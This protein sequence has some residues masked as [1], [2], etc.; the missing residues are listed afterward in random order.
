MPRGTRRFADYSCPDF[1]G[2]DRLYFD[3]GELGNDESRS[4]RINQQLHPFAPDF[5]VV[6]LRQGTGVEEITGHLAPVPFSGK[7]GVE[8]IWN[9]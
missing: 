3:Q 8:G 5:G 7:V 9:P 6:Q 4:G 2:K 1:G